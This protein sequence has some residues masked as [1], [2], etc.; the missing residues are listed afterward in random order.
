MSNQLIRSDY[1]LGLDLGRKQDH[2]ALVVIERKLQALNTRYIDIN[3]KWKETVHVRYARQWRLGVPYGDVAR[4]VAN[5]YRRIEPLGKCCLVVDQTGVGDA[6]YEMLRGE[7][8]GMNIEGVVI[9]NE[10]KR[11]IY[12]AIEVA[13]EQRM[14][15]I[16]PDVLA[17]KALKQELLTVE[18][19]RSGNSYKFGAFDKD[20]H[21]DLVMALGLAC[22]RVRSGKRPV[23]SGAKIVP[24]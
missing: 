12:A 17:A 9:T 6:V 1:Y 23:P 22:W 19:R 7:M 16:S 13:L 3:T 24:F 4:D 8:R 5:L 11:D 14:L 10:L 18:I 15:K 2:S 21:D 20:T